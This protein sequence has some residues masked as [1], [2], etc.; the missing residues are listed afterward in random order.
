MNLL[1]DELPAFDATGDPSTVDVRGIE[2]DSRRVRP[3]DLFCCLP[4]HLTDGHRH[5]GDAVGRGAVA[6][7][8]EHVIDDPAVAAV[9]Q[10]TVPEGTI[11]QA[12]AR[13]ATALFGWP[14]RD[15]AVA[16]VT[17]TNGKTTVTGL[18]G[19]VLEHDGR[20]TTVIGTLTGERTTPESIDLQRM[21]AEV[22]DRQQGDGV[23]RAVSLEVSSHALVQARVDGIRFDVVGF[24][25]LSRDHLDF[26]GSME[27]YGNAK[28]LLFEPDR[29]ERGVVFADDDWGQHLLAN[30]RIPLVAVHLADASDVVIEPRRSEFTWRGLRVVLALTGR[31]NIANALVAAEMAVAMGVDPEVVAEGLELAST[32]PGRMEVVV[33]AGRDGSQFTVVVDYAHTPAGLDA[34]LTEARELA[35]DAG[36]VVAVFG[37]GGDRDRGKRPVMGEVAARL[38]DRAYLTSDNPRHEDPLEIIDE[39]LRGVPAGAAVVVEPDRRAAIELALRE[40]GPGDVVVVAGKGHETYQQVGDERHHFD[41]REVVTEILEARIPGSVAG[42]GTR[43]KV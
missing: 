42:P 41:D 13:V 33:S 32:P 40:A 8:C 11:R 39:V 28:A 7:L 25:N 16:G 20:P 38:A 22:R 10:A 30:A 5:A 21:L 31:I 36:A 3:G 12:M 6:L 43:G 26:H 9:V 15:L 19:A 1:L 23:A 17:G 27:E 35:A 4:G 37:C 2:H 24:T 14:A 18:L 29:A 34:A